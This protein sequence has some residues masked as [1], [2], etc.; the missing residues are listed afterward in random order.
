MNLQ[1]SAPKGKLT[2][3]AASWIGRLAIGIA[4]LT[5]IYHLVVAFPGVG[6]PA[7][8][9]FLPSH[10]LLILLIV[11]F[12]DLSK[13]LRSG[14]WAKVLWDVIVIALSVASLG[15]LLTNAEANAVRMHYA[16]IPTLTEI[17]LGTACMV[18]ILD[19]ARRS[20]G[21]SLVWLTLAFFVFA[22]FGKS[23][24]GF[25]WNSGFSYERIIEMSY[26][27]PDGLWSEALSVSAGTVMIFVLFASLLLASGAG[28]FFTD[29][30][31][32]A[33]GRTPGGPAKAAV[34][35]S[36]LFGT[37]NGSA[38]ANVMTTG[39]FTIPMMK[40]VGYRAHFAAATEAVASTG[41]QFMPPI[42]GAAAFLMVELAGIPY[43]QIIIH[44]SIP[45]F[46]YFLAVF[47]TVD[48]EARRLGLARYTD[49]LPVLSV[50]LR[51]KGYLLLPVVA[52]MYF[53]FE[54]YSPS[55]AAFWATVS[56]AV[57]TL[58]LDAD[59][60]SKAMEVVVQTLVDAPKMIAPVTIACAVAGIITGMIVMS[61]VGLKV[62]S[63]V[64]DLSGGIL[65]VALLLTLLVSIILGLGLPTVT[66][67]LILAALLAPG[68]IKLGASPV[69]AHLFIIYAA[70][71]A[72]ITPPVALT[73]FAAA[74]IAEAD[75]WET[76]WSAVK[77]GLSVYIIPFMF[78]FGPGLLLIGDSG[79]V[80]GTL[81]T[82]TVGIIALSATVIGWFL[83]PLKLIER[84]ISM[85]GAIMLIDP[86][87]ITDLIGFSL[88]ALVAILAIRRRMK[89]NLSVASAS[90][91]SD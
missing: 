11:F 61:G 71:M 86:G 34:V 58:T 40:K 85:I 31:L 50:V 42:M 45:A 84:A 43:S 10:L 38:V 6:Q 4:I 91:A 41:G 9:R 77:L 5:S 78:V 65:I 17:I 16:E 67:Y 30:A 48:F 25:L 82:A 54:G 68:L 20:L 15:Y 51:R 1:S 70:S 72:G 49:A 26:L 66:A 2:E 52:L 87:L 29:I 27:T 12:S 14:E 3:T 39:A 76:S 44:A 33:A 21:W 79:E 28:T 7:T 19:A 18:A 36:A 24:P 55:T 46:L 56:L 47:V 80:I 32:A 73:S 83:V 74:A 89:Q 53:L 37:L 13:H 60:R 62:S 59:N 88:V 35:S 23:M 69:A 8:Y 81:I 22:Y 57:L 75:P 90:V 64:L 63:I